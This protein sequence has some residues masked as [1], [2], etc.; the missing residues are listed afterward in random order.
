MHLHP[1]LLISCLSVAGE[2]DEGFSIRSAF[3]GEGEGPPRATHAWAVVSRKTRASRK[4]TG[5]LDDASDAPMYLSRFRCRALSPTRGHRVTGSRLAVTPSGEASDRREEREREKRVR[6]YAS[7]VP[8]IARSTERRAY[9]RALPKVRQLLALP[10][11]AV[12]VAPASANR[13]SPSRAARQ[14]RPGTRHRRSRFSCARGSRQSSSHR[15]DGGFV[16]FPLSLLVTFS[17][18]RIQ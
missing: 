6:P 12:L 1:H 2:N 4:A 7:R 10:A 5:T 13:R 16:P 15:Q 8:V 9:A 11:R 14:S 17:I 3:A 18:S